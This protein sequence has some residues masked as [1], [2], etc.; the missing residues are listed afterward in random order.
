MTD[1]D[2]QIKKAVYKIKLHQALKGCNFNGGG[3]RQLLQEFS[4]EVNGS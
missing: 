1:L 4:D 2:F 3:M